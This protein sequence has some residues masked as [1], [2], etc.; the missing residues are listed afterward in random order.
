MREALRIAGRIG[1][2]TL[3]AVSSL[4][5][6]LFAAI[7]ITDARSNAR[8]GAVVLLVPALALLAGGIYGLRRTRRILAPSARGG[9]VLDAA[10][11]RVRAGEPVVLYPSRRR[12]T[13]LLAGFVLFTA[14]SAWAFADTGGVV[15]AAGVLLFGAGLVL[16]VL[17]LIPG[18][19]YLRIAPDGLVARTPVKTSRWAWNDIEQFEAYEIHHRYGSTKQVG[20]DRRDLTPER[21]G[22]WQTIARGMSGVDAA[23][24]DT[25]GLDHRDLADLLDEARDRYATEHGVSESERADLAL[26][27]QAAR[28]RQDRIPAVTALLTA[29]CVAAFA[30]ETARYGL[31]P[32][33]GALLDAGAAS[34]DALA[35][36]RWWTLLT[37]NVLHGNLIHLVLNLIAFVLLGWLLEREVGWPRFGLLCAIGGIVAMACAV[38]LQI[39]AGT[40]GLS[41]VVFAVAGW[42]VLRDTHR[43]RAL[44]VVAWAILPVGVIYTFLTPGISIGGHVGGLLTGL[45]LGW[46]FERRSHV[47]DDTLTTAESRAN[48]S[49]AH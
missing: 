8:I 46:A 48:L 40:V 3:T 27:A 47:S 13:L 28:V 2:W 39:G 20:F 12:W 14:S 17:Q 41:G 7:A 16:A 44:G 21:Q 29:A 30:V 37:A 19:A 42:A 45:G 23:L 31:F 24:P 9:A 38:L 11:V 32:G 4:A 26:A 25:Y 35:D 18:R 5:V 49:R 22:F 43:T 15:F 34:R 10:L 36:G 6:V 1:L 33:T